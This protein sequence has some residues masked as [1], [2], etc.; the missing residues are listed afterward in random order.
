VDLATLERICAWLQKEGCGDGLPGALL[1][2]RPSAL[3][4]AAAAP[5]RVK[6][7]VAEYRETRPEGTVRAR[8]SRDDFNVAARI[9]QRLCT[10]PGKR[11]QLSFAYGHIPLHVPAEGGDVDAA[12]IRRD[13]ASG[14][15]ADREVAKKGAAVTNVLIGSQ[16]SNLLQECFVARLFN[17]KAHAAPA[18]PLPFYLAFQERQRVAS[19]F[20]GN[21]PPPGADA[22]GGAGVY[23]RPSGGRRWR[24]L[25]YEPMRR[26][27][28]IVIVRRHADRERLDIAVFGLTG[29][30][31]AAMGKVLCE[32]PE[33]FWPEDAQRPVAAISAYAC[34]FDLAGMHDW[35]QDIESINIRNPQV[36]PLE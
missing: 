17:V 35:E 16:H 31:T 30:C 4:E 15:E 29:L 1:G 11:P 25:P 24:Y 27:A 34:G 20:G 28:G 14:R 6:F 7:W 32:M 12:V 5:G 8:V 13:C 9:I 18:E 22:A 3:L 23:Y 19:C 21:A 33:S 36:V 2:F 10:M 26:G